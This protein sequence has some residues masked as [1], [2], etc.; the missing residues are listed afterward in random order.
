[1]RCEEAGALLDLYLDGCLPLELSTK[2][3]RHLLRCAACPGE[4]RS[5]E[6]TIALLREASSPEQPSPSF[7]ERAAARLQSQL[8]GH[9]RSTSKDDVGRQWILPFTGTEG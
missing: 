6:Q 4:L 7:R 2:L 5:L 9:L 3:D 1:M 8:A